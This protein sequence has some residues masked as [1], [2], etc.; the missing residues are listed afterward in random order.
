MWRDDCWHIS[1]LAKIT[2][3]RFLVKFQ[4]NLCTTS[5]I[6][7]WQVLMVH[8]RVNKMF[9]GHRHLNMRCKSTIMKWTQ[10][11][12]FT[13]MIRIPNST[14][15][16]PSDLVQTDWVE[17]QPKVPIIADLVL[18]EDS[19]YESTL[20]LS[21]HRFYDLAAKKV[22]CPTPFSNHSFCKAA[23][24]AWGWGNSRGVSGCSGWKQY[25]ES[26]QLCSLHAASSRPHVIVY[27]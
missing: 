26:M 1:M 14:N 22:W 17:P 10:K 8:V 4:C 2:L 16:V 15:E 24:W 20:L 11:T 18:C 12:A 6:A 9:R 13:W 21:H 27:E 25:T 7:R 19:S 5:Q 3:L 23:A